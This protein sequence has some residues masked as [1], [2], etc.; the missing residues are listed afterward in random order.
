M[1]QMRKTDYPSNKQNESRIIPGIT[2]RKGALL[3]GFLL[4]LC[5]VAA[6]LSGLDMAISNRIYAAFGGVFPRSNWWLQDVLHDGV[7]RVFIGIVV[8]LVVL[9]VVPPFL[10]KDSGWQPKLRLFMLSGLLFIGFDMLL[11][12]MTSFPCPW[13]LEIFG[14]VKQM[15]HFTAMFD[16]EQYGRGHCFP[17][18]HSSSGYFWLG[19]AFIFAA[20]RPHGALY[21]LALLPLGLT[22]S[23]TQLLRGAHFL[24]H[25]LATMGLAFILFSTLPVL[26]MKACEAINC[27]RAHKKVTA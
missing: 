22:L 23:V 4:L 10:R 13:S 19:L 25:E 9:S 2:L 6:N 24:S 18:G 15:P 7:H 20:N 11:K 26:L 17:A 12:S 27:C 16:L 5:S 14:G 1:P 21:V 8:L 3:C